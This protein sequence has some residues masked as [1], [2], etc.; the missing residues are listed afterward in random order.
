MKSIAALFLM[1]VALGSAPS[2]AGEILPTVDIP[3]YA[4]SL[5]GTPYRLGGSDPQLGLDCS[6][7]VNHVFRQTAGLQLPRESQAISQI[8]LELDPAELQP[9]DLV[10]FNT[11]DRPFSHVGIYLGDNRFVHAASSRSG[12]VMLSSLSDSYW[13]RRFEGARRV[14]TAQE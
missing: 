4:V 2:A 8:G 9:G 14:M 10:F 5:V 1:C 13:T 12:G 7:F 11:L 3:M 6:G